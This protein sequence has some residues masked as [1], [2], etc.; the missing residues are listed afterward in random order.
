MQLI[1]ATGANASY[2]ERITPYLHSIQRH[3]GSFDR[4][5]LVTVGCKVEMPDELDMIEAIPLPAERA[6]GHT[7]IWCIQ[8]GCHLEVLSADDNDV[9]IF[10]DGDIVLQRGL[11]I[12][13]VSW[14][15]AIPSMTF[16]LGW[17]AGPHDTLA[18]EANRLCLTQEGRAL[19]ADV[20]GERIYNCG[21]IVCRV[22]AYKA[23]YEEYLKL[24]PF[25][26]PHTRHY[27]ATQF[28][29]CAIIARN[30][31][32]VWDLPY[33]VH[34]HGCFGVPEGVSDQGWVEDLP[35]LFLHH[36]MS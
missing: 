4:R 24:W 10:T 35:V 7:G 9:V 21:V 5:V 18:D 33:T 31:W 17:N 8:Q 3:A 28:L 19:F 12:D 23:L 34:T 11:T 25:Y 32:R 20:L 16:G 29:L 27:A 14:M 26:S 1:L 36:W 13:E 15:R 6:L 30:G 2:I 22:G